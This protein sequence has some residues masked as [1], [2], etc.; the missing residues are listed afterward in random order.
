MVGLAAL[1][2]APATVLTGTVLSKDGCGVSGLTISGGGDTTSTKQGGQ[3]VLRLEPLP[4][5]DPK[6][7][8]P[9]EVVGLQVQ[10]V[11]ARCVV[12]WPL[13]LR[14]VIP[15]A[16]ATNIVLAAS[17]PQARQALTA[18]ELVN[19]VG[20]LRAVL[21]QDS[22]K[23]GE[24]LATLLQELRNG[25]DSAVQAELLRQIFEERQTQ[26]EFHRELRAL[27][28]EYLFAVKELEVAFRRNAPKVLENCAYLPNFEEPI[29]DYN[30][31][32]GSWETSADTIA[33]ELK[34]LDGSSL[35]GALLGLKASVRAFHNPYLLG[36]SEAASANEL[37]NSLADWCLSPPKRSERKARREAIERTAEELDASLVGEGQRLRTEVDEFL[38]ALER[39]AAPAVAPV[40]PST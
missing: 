2:P 25:R 6:R 28:S 39:G 14:A 11:E 31:A 40:P 26:L 15:R 22:A 36:E 38:E 30:D 17:N 12:A 1:A 8:D 9:G 34:G 32:L 3:Y 37:K 16:D 24:L 5:Q 13:N 4:G 29:V 18:E 23:Q 10:G 35:E 7:Y 33:P 27:L 20:V 21:E 19:E